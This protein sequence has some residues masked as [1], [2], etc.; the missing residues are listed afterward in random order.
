MVEVSALAKQATAALMPLLRSGLASLVKG[1]ALGQLLTFIGMVVAGYVG[2]RHG[3]F[4]ARIVASLFVG[5]I[6]TIATLVL[7]S[8][9]AVFA[10]VQGALEKL[11]MGSALFQVVFRYLLGVSE[12][13]AP[14]QR[15]GV[16]GNA[17][18]TR[19]PLE[20]AQQ[21]LNNAIFRLK[22]EH[23]D[24]SGLRGWLLTK[25]R[26]S[27]LGLVASVTL[28]RFR[29]DDQTQGAVDL[30]RVRDE[31]GEGLDAL[32]VDQVRA[33]STRTTWLFGG[34]AAAIAA[35]TVFLIHWYW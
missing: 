29:R 9:R 6:G 12:E 33:I 19:I 27:L 21:R 24:V 5:V 10:V 28:A 11:A 8:H 4:A 26:T 7:S 25:V 15:M 34:I 2:S 16:V 3:E 1:L 30:I 20:Q 35:L 32:L 13:T 22:R 23:H 31:L 14:G 18:E 17:L